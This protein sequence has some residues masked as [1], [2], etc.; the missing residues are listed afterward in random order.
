MKEELEQ[1]KCEF[2]DQF[3]FLKSIQHPRMEEGMQISY[4]YSVAIVT[5][6][7]IDGKERGSTTLYTSGKSWI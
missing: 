1:K 5:E 3:D 2:C 7:L 6:M 4:S